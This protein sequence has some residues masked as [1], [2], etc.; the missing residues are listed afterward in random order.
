[1]PLNEIFFTVLELS[2]LPYFLKIMPKTYGDNFFTIE[3]L[4]FIRITAVKL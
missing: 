3:T 1:M 4:I 2:E